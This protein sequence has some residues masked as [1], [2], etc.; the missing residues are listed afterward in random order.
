MKHMTYTV[1]ITNDNDEEVLETCICLSCMM[2]EQQVE[3][4]RLEIVNAITAQELLDAQYY[5]VE[6]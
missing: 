1:V 6:S 4:L 3:L 2:E 5:G